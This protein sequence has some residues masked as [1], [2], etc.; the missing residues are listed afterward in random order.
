MSV[1]VLIRG[2]GVVGRSLALA[3]AAQGLRVGLRGQPQ[4]QPQDQSQGHSQ[5]H[6][7]A[8]AHD[9]RAY[10]LN[11]ASQALLARLR[12]WD[13]LPSEARTP[14]ADMRISATGGRLD[15]S[16]WQAHAEQLAWIVDA[17]ELDTQLDAALRFAPHVQRLPADA[18]HA[19]LALCEGREASSRAQLG[20]AAHERPYGHDALATRL[21]ADQAHQGRAWQW[22]SDDGE[23]LALLPLDRPEPGRSYALVWSQ[24]AERAAERVALSAADFEQ[25]LRARTDQALR[26]VAPRQRWPLRLLRATAMA[27]EGFVLLGDCAHLVHPLAGQGLNLGLADVAALAEVLAAR[28]PWR[29]LGDAKLLRRY[30][31][32]RAADTWL[33]GEFT[34]LIWA[35]LTQAPPWARRAAAGGL[36]V[37]DSLGPVKRWL[38]QQAMGLSFPR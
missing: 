33:M 38:S 9:V 8:R 12:V 18:P 28:E 10:A 1:D 26:L 32:A 22:F 25:Q 5:D 20:V 17:A 6:S 21:V 37:V 3:L 34:D 29:P 35:G 36:S 27:G 19:L 24:P 2:D 7:P 14:V 31:R 13:S 23:I 11:A 4:D 15:F 16:A 30:A